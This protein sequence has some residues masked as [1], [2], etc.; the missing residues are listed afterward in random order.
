[1]KQQPQQSEEP[2][3]C[4]RC[5]SEQITAN[6]RGFNLKRAV[7]VGILTFGVA[8]V[9]GVAAGLIGRNKVVLT[10]LKCGKQWKAGSA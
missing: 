6:K 7:G 1:M 3:R 4:P 5:G 8:S 2:V 9:P 10:C